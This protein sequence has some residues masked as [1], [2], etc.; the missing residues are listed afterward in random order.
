LT[1]YLE[2][3]YKYCFSAVG[4]MHWVGALKSEMCEKLMLIYL[5]FLVATF[6]DGFCF[7]CFAWVEILGFNWQFPWL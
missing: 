2:N 6:P 3:I 7:K 4:K 1:L 5:K